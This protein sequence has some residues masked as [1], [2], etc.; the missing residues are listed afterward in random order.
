MKPRYC[1]KRPNYK[2][3]VPKS[4]IFDI[5]LSANDEKSC[6]KLLSF[7]TKQRNV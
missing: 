7:L 2:L 5:F 1:K 6:L 3:C 4:F